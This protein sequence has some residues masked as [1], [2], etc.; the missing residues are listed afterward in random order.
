MTNSFSP[1]KILIEENTEGGSFTYLRDSLNA[2]QI[3]KQIMLEV[4]TFGLTS[5][6]HWRSKEEK[7]H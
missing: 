5:L 4:L 7:S 3:R 2:I 6:H 1:F